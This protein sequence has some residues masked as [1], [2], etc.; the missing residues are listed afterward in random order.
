MARV[1][2]QDWLNEGLKLLAE[3]GF[4]GLTLENLLPRL[5]V[6][7]GSFYHHFKNRR[8][9]T[10]ALLAHWQQTL[11]EEIVQATAQR[12]DVDRR[13]E[14][15]IALAS[16]LVDQRALERA[17]RAEATVDPMVRGYVE[18]VDALRLAH[19]RRLATQAC[20]D[21]VRGRLLGNLA[22][23]VFLGTQQVL[24]GFSEE[25]VMALYRELL[26]IAD[27]KD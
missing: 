4:K 15:L 12:T 27:R 24:P 16:E 17:I 2:R 14:E 22:H 7:H 8:H 13:V 20:G 10:E 19:S 3:Q 1:S 26:R 18:Q 5:G 21:E 23:A 9:Y 6:T 11:T 25:E